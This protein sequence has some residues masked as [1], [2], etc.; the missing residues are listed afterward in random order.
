MITARIRRA[1]DAPVNQKKLHRIL[2]LNQRQCQRRPLIDR[3]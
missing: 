2:K 1:A 3:G